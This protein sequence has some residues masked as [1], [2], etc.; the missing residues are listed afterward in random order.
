MFRSCCCGFL[1]FLSM[2]SGLQGD[3]PMLLWNNVPGLVGD[4][5]SLRQPLWFPWLRFARWY[6]GEYRICTVLNRKYGDS[7][8]CRSWQQKFSDVS[9]GPWSL[10]S[11]HN[12]I[13]RWILN[14]SSPWTP[15]EMFWEKHLL[16]CMHAWNWLK[17]KTGSSDSSGHMNFFDCMTAC[18][19]ML[20]LLLR[21][22]C[23]PG[24]QQ[25]SDRDT[26]QQLGSQESQVD[27]GC[28]RYSSQ[29]ST[30]NKESQT[31]SDPNKQMKKIPLAA[32]PVPFCSFPQ[33]QMCKSKQF[34]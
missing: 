33:N 15:E 14:H 17:A 27:Q 6:N 19:A 4:F 23:I 11:C 13:P 28:A 26:N 25:D 21:P 10:T 32:W 12:L 18:M 5:E 8:C 3:W 29:I 2:L 16:E 22:F 34:N 7:R 9:L 30:K 24:Q 1:N 31:H 20:P